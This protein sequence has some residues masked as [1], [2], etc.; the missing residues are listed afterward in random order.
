MTSPLPDP[1]ELTSRLIQIDTS[2]PPGNE[3]A[4]AA[5]LAPLLEKAGYTVEMHDM[6]PGRPNLVARISWGPEPPLLLTGHMDTVTEGGEQWER[7]PFGGEVA[8]GLVHGRGASD[9]KSGLAAL[10]V[11]AM[12]LAQ[13]KPTKS[14]LVLVFTASE[15]NGCQGAEHLVQNP[16]VLGG[17]G[18]MLVAEP[19]ANLPVLGHKG[20]LWLRGHCAGK[21]AHG[22]MPELG[23]NAIYKAAAAVSQLAAYQFTAQPHPVLGRATLNVGTIS[24]GRA[25][26]VVP[27]KAEFTVDLRLIPGL[28][29]D[30]V[31][32]E[33]GRFL[34]DAVSL[35]RIVGAGALWTEAEHPWIARVL[36]ILA[37]RRGQSFAPAGVPYF[38]DGSA[39]SRALG[40]VP[41]LLLGPGEPGKAHVVNESCPVANIQQ[42]AADY[43]AI[44]KDWCGA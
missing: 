20:A 35:E 2:N 17:A 29:P 7:G 25:T 12:A 38:T 14:G 16:A 27:E 34:G 10:T 24:G 5:V 39:L 13:E 36:E 9:M 33:L 8:Q 43:L 6:A 30:E 19:T 41:S 1:V 11:A 31:Q 3:G 42:A 26:N 44:V 40:G 23:D 32:A 18:A 37:Q 15:E 22:S 4:V 28:E 21:A